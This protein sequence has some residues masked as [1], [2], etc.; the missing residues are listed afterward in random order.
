MSRLVGAISRRISRGAAV[1][2]V[3][4]G[5]KRAKEQRE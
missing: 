4:V 2:A 3:R 5:A 1:S